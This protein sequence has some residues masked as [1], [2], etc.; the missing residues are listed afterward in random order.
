MS[1]FKFPS[2]PHFTEDKTRAGRG[3][4]TYPSLHTWLWSK[5]D[6]SSNCPP[7]GGS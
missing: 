6:L 4:V 1:A 5:A 7:G 3:A 2:R